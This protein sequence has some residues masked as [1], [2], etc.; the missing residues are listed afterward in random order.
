MKRHE[1]LATLVAPKQRAASN[2]EMQAMQSEQA[3]LHSLLDERKGAEIGNRGADRGEL[4]GNLFA[5]GEHVGLQDVQIVEQREPSPNE[6]LRGRVAP[7]LLPIGRDAAALRMAEHDDVRH[8]DGKRGKF[9]FG[10]R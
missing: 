6:T 1:A 3:F 7:H 2:V 10:A 4:E 8:L 9:D 5:V